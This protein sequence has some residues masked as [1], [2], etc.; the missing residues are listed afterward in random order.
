V[1]VEQE[2]RE[3]VNE[4][5]DDYWEPIEAGVGSIPQAYLTL[6]EVDRRSVRE[7]VKARLSPFES[8][9]RLSLS[10]EMLIGSGRA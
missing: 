2:I 5:F 9:G 3:D 7:E 6:S 4:S 1:R 10:V 8:N